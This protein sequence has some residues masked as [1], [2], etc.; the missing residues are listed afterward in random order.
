MKTLIITR[1]ELMREAGLNSQALRTAEKKA[2]LA[3]ATQ[4][5]GAYNLAET[6]RLLKAARRRLAAN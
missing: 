1:R 4:R 5:R 3:P 6:R 2:G